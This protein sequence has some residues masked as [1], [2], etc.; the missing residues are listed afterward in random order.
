MKTRLLKKVNN[1]IRIITNDR[2]WFNIEVRDAYTKW[3][4]VREFKTFGEAHL[5]KKHY[6]KNILI[7]DFGLEARYKQKLKQW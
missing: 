5:Q 6:I 2:D 3:H 7:K 1:R 4:K